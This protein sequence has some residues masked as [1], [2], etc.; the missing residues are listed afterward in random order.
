[1]RIFFLATMLLLT[2]CSTTLD[3]APVHIAAPVADVTEVNNIYRDGRFYFS[4]QPQPPALQTLADR[5]VVKVINLRTQ[6]EMD[7]RVEFD[8][9]ALLEELDVE[10]VHLPFPREGRDEW[11]D[12]FARELART[13]GPVLIH[14][15]SSS[16]VG[17]VWGRYLRLNRGF[18]AEDALLRAK[19]AG[20]G[21]ESLLEWVGSPVPHAGASR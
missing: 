6:K 15:G 7:E 18:S 5:G 11:M 9:P 8:E 20:T 2:G 4:G 12:L 14:C 1:M 16:R 21:S 19:A 10:Y 17:G 3:K 13:R